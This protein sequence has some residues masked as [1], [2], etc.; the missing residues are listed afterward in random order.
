MTMHRIALAFPSALLALSLACDPGSKSVS[1]TATADDDGGGDDEGSTTV[2]DDGGAGDG[3]SATSGP[4]SGDAGEDGTND[5]ADEP[6]C[7]EA[8]TPLSG[9]DEVSPLGFPASEL[10]ALSN[11]WSTTFGWFPPD[12]PIDVVP[13][14][15]ETTLDIGLS[16][17]GGPIVY[18]ES[19][20]NP[21]SPL[22]IAPD[23][24][25]RIEMEVEVVFRTG[26][27]RFDE[28]F[29]TT[30]IATGPD[31]MSFRETFAPDGFAGTFSSAEV[32][33]GEDD[34]IVEAFDL[35]GVFAA[36]AAPTGDLAIQIVVN[37]GDGPDG[38][39]AGYGI[40]ASWPAG[41]P[42]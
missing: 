11:G 39:F 41:L 31:A 15:T 18:V 8:S 40:L 13:A 33:F 42:E 27:G 23:C 37:I 9:P 5:P 20:P 1:G 7:L 16:Y 12:G 14:G 4:P 6:L 19:E 2:G 34:G 30:A 32:S 36:D 3:L 21:D 10:V 24:D 38:G 35:N 28:Q 25:D 29:L 26:D 17:L 22:D